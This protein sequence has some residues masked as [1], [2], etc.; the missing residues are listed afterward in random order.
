[1]FKSPV[2]GLSHI[3]ENLGIKDRQTDESV[4]VDA[5]DKCLPEVREYFGQILVL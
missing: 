5:L 4:L 1:M 2:L 3:M